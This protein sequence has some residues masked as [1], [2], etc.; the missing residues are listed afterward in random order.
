MPIQAP[1]GAEGVFYNVVLGERNDH[2][3]MDSLQCHRLS[4]REVRR[5]TARCRSVSP[6]T[7]ALLVAVNAALETPSGFVVPWRVIVG[8]RIF[9]SLHPPNSVALATEAGEVSVEAAVHRALRGDDQVRELRS[10][11]VE[12]A[13]RSAPLL[14]HIRERVHRRSVVHWFYKPE[15]VKTI[16]YPSGRELFE[17]LIDSW[18]RNLPHLVEFPDGW[19]VDGLNWLA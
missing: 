5:S 13:M 18:T 19:Y 12:R 4:S 10:R 6:S 17:A 7:E 8:A 16:A 2:T 3:P 11:Q 15:D 14:D 1:P 9:A